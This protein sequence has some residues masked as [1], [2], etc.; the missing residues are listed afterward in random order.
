MDEKPGFYDWGE[1]TEEDSFNKAGY[2]NGL[3]EPVT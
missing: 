3:P 2:F 1:Y